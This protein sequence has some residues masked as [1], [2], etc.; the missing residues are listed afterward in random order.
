MRTQI[1]VSDKRAALISQVTLGCVVKTRIGEP[2]RGHSVTPILRSEGW[3][4]SQEKTVSFTSISL[5][6]D[7]ELEDGMRSCRSAKAKKEQN[8]LGA[9]RID[10]EACFK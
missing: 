2:P 10:S 8:S 4:V 1:A 5:K 3:K 7:R 9:I 6:T